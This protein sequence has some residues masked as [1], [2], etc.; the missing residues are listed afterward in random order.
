VKERAR[1]IGALVGGVAAAVAYVVVRVIERVQGGPVDPRMIL[2]ESHV[3]FY[4]RVSIGGWWGV[5]VAAVVY[6]WLV[7][8]TSDGGSAGLVRGI[9]RV[10]VPIAIGLAL[11]AWWLP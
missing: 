2:A 4:W 3:A 9:A 10:V 7:R 1:A 6:A 8:R 11:L 5:V